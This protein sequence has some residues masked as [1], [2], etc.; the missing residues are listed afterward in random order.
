MLF[1]S[2]C[3]TERVCVFV[4]SSVRYRE[5][6]CVFS[7]VRYRESVC[8]FSSVRYREC[9]GGDGASQVSLSDEGAAGLALLRPLKG[10]LLA[11]H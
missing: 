8:V 9:V 10:R 7:S 11:S 1:R 3:V 4:F 5:C 2:V 6:V